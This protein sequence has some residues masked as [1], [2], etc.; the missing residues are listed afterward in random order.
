MGEELNLIN[1]LEVTVVVAGVIG[2]LYSFG[3]KLHFRSVEGTAT[4]ATHAGAIACWG[5]CVVIA[6]VAL[7]L[8]VMG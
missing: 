6:L 3:L 7:A 8:M 1:V 2:G 5:A 4:V